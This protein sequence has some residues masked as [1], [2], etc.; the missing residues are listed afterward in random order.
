M[1]SKNGTDYLHNYDF[2]VKWLAEALKGQTLDAIGIKTGQV[3]EVFAFEPVDIAVKAGRVDVMVR[4]DAGALFHIEEQRDLKRSDLYRF[5]AYHFLGAKKWG[6]GMV[7]VILASGDVQAGTRSLKTASGVYEPVVLDFSDRNGEK[8]LAEIRAEVK[9]GTFKNWLELVVLPLYGK[10][11]GEERARFVEEVVRFEVALF[12]A[13]KISARL[14][15]A[16]LILSNKMMDKKRLKA[17]W[18]EIK[19]LDIIEI[20]REKGIEEGLDRGKSLGIVEGKSL[21]IVEGKSLG[22]QEGLDRG[23]SLGSV[24][25]A[26]EMLLDLLFEKFGAVPD[27][28]QDEIGRIDSLFNLK[29][30]FRQA[31][32]CNDMEAFGGMVH[33]VRGVSEHGDKRGKVS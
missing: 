28:M 32:K 8:R 22:I 13:N 4:D 12:R 18:E 19:M 1:Q 7:D 20:A 5:A 14:T 25:I 16:T 15:A 2:I 33:R 29:T 26:R 3:E 31:F 24:E 17:M 10:A 11:K 9:A 30:L 23:K 27:E 21:G 6:P